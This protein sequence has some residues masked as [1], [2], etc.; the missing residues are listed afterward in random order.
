M[1][2]SSILSSIFLLTGAFF[3]IVGSI[4]L[5]RLPDVYTRLH[6]TTKCDTLGQALVLLGVIFYEG[7]TFT[8]VKVLLI[9]IFVL[10]ANPTAAHALAK[11]AYMYGVKPC[12][13]TS[14][15]MYKE[16]VKRRSK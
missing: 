2:T 3:F 15:D 8:S 11:G 9:A 14:L 7:A 6:A 1:I 10:I 16:K 5:N 13:I 4:G 12:E